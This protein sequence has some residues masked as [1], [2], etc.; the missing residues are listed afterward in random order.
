MS[1]SVVK[2]HLEITQL[3]K[4][5]REAMNRKIDIDTL[6]SLFLARGV[7]HLSSCREVLNTA[8]SKKGGAK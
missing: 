2:A 5:R 4:L 3:A 6:A 7:K 1:A 8:T